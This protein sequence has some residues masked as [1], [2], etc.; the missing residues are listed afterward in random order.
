MLKVL[1][2][3]R[4]VDQVGVKGDQR[5]LGGEDESPDFLCLLREKL[6]LDF[7]HML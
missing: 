3:N 2:S 7:R 4:T 6:Q 1:P 5:K